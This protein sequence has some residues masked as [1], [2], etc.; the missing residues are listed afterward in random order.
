MFRKSEKIFEITADYAC[1]H[2]NAAYRGRLVIVELRSIQTEI[3]K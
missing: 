1:N 2:E 3:Q